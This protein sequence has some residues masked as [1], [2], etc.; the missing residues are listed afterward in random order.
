MI[1]H[2]W[3]FTKGGSPGQPCRR[4]VAMNFWGDI[5]FFA[6]LPAC[7]CKYQAPVPRHLASVLFIQPQMENVRDNAFV[8]NTCRLSFLVV[9]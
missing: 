3:R 4:G 6:Q 8:L 2:T 9:I 1:V 5:S 7:Y